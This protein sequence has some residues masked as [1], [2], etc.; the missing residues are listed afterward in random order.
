LTKWFKKG[1]S[2]SKEFKS[3]YIVTTHLLQT[4]LPRNVRL[5]GL[6]AAEIYAEKCVYL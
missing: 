5:L 1:W 4:V 3:S 6:K 2:R